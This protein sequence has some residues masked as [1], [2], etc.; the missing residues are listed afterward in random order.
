MAAQVGPFAAGWLGDELVLERSVRDAAGDRRQY[1]WLDQVSLAT[2]VL[3]EAADLLPA[4]RLQPAAEGDARR[5]AA[6]PYRL[7][8][9]PVELPL[10]P[11][12]QWL[13][14]LAWL[15]VVAG[16]GSAVALAV[17]SGR[18]AERRAA[19]V[20]AVTHEL[21]T[22]LT[23]LRL[24]ADLLADERVGGDAVR[25][26]GAVERLRAEAIRL[27]HLVEN[28]LDYA[29]LERRPPRPTLVP[30]DALL[31]SLLPRLGERLAAAGLRLAVG[32]PLPAAAC[33]CDA[34][35][36]ERILANLIDNAA[37]Y[38]VGAVDPTV[39]LACEVDRR[40]I[41]IR[42]IDHGPGLDDGARA[43]LFRPFARSAEDAA[44]SAPGIGLGLALCQ[45]MA[46]ANHGRL[47]VTDTPGGGVTVELELPR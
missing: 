46:A 8:P 43:R 5:L 2:L 24:H 9:G 19:F 27:G 3:A 40:W 47:R 7:D 13:L 28:V 10:S 17:L 31:T 15:G 32:G 39:T 45:R 30:V 29:R 14:A 12:T 36:V 35:A 34:A 33:R 42:V 20:S 38:A 37:K 41:M 23:A 18:L 25:R 26:A 16:S 1:V 22:P 4:A 11:G 44:G 21:R 6:L